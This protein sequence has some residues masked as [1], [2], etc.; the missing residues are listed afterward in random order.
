MDSTTRSHEMS[1]AE[2]AG[3]SGVGSKMFYTTKE[4]AQVLGISQNTVLAE[5]A[6][7][8]MRYHLPAGRKSGMLVRAEWV[9]EWIG[10]GTHV[11]A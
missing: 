7:G 1:F 5:I 2:F 9:D 8:R 6:A 4:V 11:R 10:E 3:H